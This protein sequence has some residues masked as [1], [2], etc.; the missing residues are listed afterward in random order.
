MEALIWEAGGLLNRPGSASPAIFLPS[1]DYR[2]PMFRGSSCFLSSPLKNH[3]RMFG[4]L[5]SSRVILVKGILFLI[6]GLMAAGV[7]LAE[8]PGMR[9]FVLLSTCVW[10][11]CRFY[12][13]AFYVI[14][15]YVDPG[16]RFAGLG[17][18]VYYLW[19]RSRR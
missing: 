2:L 6:A 15:H 9:T 10:C 5:K 17:S 14:Q 19:Q 1:R 8:N 12:Y 3:V 18:F 4:D 16:Y 11:F 7:L 13:F